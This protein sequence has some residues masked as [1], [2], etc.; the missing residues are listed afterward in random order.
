MNLKES[1]YKKVE[2]RKQKIMQLKMTSNVQN[3][4]VQLKK[5]HKTLHSVYKAKKDY[6][7]NFSIILDFD[8]VYVPSV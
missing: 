3:K 7:F 4:V 2:L 6:A 8:S 1:S 5:Q